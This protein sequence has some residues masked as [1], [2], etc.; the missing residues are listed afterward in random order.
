[1]APPDD[2]PDDPESPA[3]S[4]RALGSN[5]TSI[6]DRIQ[7]RDA[8]RALVDARR[9]LSQRTWE[10][11]ARAAMAEHLVV[12]DELDLDAPLPEGADAEAREARA[13]LLCAR[14]SRAVLRG[15]EET[16]LAEWTAAIA[17]APDA[18]DGYVLRGALRGAR[19]DTEGALADLDR[20]AELAPNDASAFYRRGQLFAR[21]GDHD[22]ALANYRRAA[23]VA[24]T[25][26]ANLVA[27]AESFLSLGDEAGAIG[28]LDRA[29]RAGPQFAD[30]F[31]HRA[32]CHARV[33]NHEAALR[34]YEKS[35]EI[36]PAQLTALR[37]R[38]ATLRGLGRSADALADLGRAAALAPDDADVRQAFLWAHLAADPEAATVAQLTELIGFSPED[39]AL[40][41]LRAGA[42]ARAKDLPAAA[43]DYETAMRLDPTVVHHVVGLSTVRCEMDGPEQSLLYL[44]RIIALSPPDAELWAAHARVRRMEGNV[45]E[46]LEDFDMAVSLH[47]SSAEL[48]RERAIVLYQMERYADAAAGMTSAIVL[49]PENG[50]NH[51]W[52]GYCR[53]YLD[54]PREDVAADF[55]RAIELAPDRVVPW[56]FRAQFLEGEE[57]W[58]DAIADLER[59]MTFEPSWG[60]ILFRRGVCR[61]SLA[62]EVACADADDEEA[63]EEATRQSDELSRGAIADFERC[64]ELGTK[65]I[66]VYE[67]LWIAHAGLGD[68][69]GMLAALGGAIT[70]DPLVAWPYYHRSRLLGSRGDD[71]G[72]R[73]DMAKALAL[74]FVIADEEELVRLRAYSGGTAG[75]VAES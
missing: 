3:P 1:M 19:K 16:A 60:V 65:K 69:E 9:A 38:S 48:Q 14:G 35:L 13:A 33:G 68:E 30:L 2:P 32:T 49:E 52:R 40:Y 67:E 47:P 72:A 46:A 11:E 26:I 7:R 5:V 23:Q 73:R 74:G 41:G 51:A 45:D 24:P 42:Y 8:Q 29:V 17:A 10:A 20:A 34:D 54:D 43:A 27:M 66:E 64:L 25:L 57:R 18:A 39:D 37:L 50:E 22:R 61:S 21:Q 75:G 55:A 59:A 6:V 62:N 71:A 53:R 31:L 56:F 4:S 36:N 12:L 44:D 28:A 58:T 15:D 70:L 63:E